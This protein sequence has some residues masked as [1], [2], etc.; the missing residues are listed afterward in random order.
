MTER[1]GFYVDLHN[2]DGDLV[3]EFRQIV[4]LRNKVTHGDLVEIPREKAS[5]A[6]TLLTK[7]LAAEL[8]LP[9]DWPP[10]KT[11]RIRHVELDYALRT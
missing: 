5:E 1:F 6:K 9:D 11:P 10:E 3:E 4:A 2:W 8:G 7:M